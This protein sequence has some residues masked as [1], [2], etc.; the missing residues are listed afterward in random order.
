MNWIMFF[1]KIEM[2][3]ESLAIINHSFQASFDPNEFI[4]TSQYNHLFFIKED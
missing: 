3:F 2:N 1:I 4:Y